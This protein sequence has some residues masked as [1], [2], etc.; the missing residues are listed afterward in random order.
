MSDQVRHPGVQ[1][2]SGSSLSGFALSSLVFGVLGFFTVGFT[3][4][5]AVI[6][7]HIALFQIRR[8]GGRWTG[9][10][11]AISGLV[12][13]YLGVL[14]FIGFYFSVRSLLVE[15]EKAKVRQS[16]FKSFESALELYR[17]NAGFYPSTGQGLD[18]L[19][20]EPE[21]APE[22]KRWSQI[23]RK[24]PVDTWGRAYDYRF[25]GSINPEKPEIIWRGPDGII[26]SADDV[27]SQDP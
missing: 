23:M 18:A 8:S 14:Q 4:I 24:L 9:R 17:L 2:D 21:L 22:P 3:G 10:W 11:L 15:A 7:G 5:I 16:D 6:L 25:P 26:G 12:T 13:G 20:E 27:S 19:V 1:P